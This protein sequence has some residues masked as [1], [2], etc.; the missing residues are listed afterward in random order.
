[1]FDW[2]PRILPY[3]GPTWAFCD[4]HGELADTETDWETKLWI[5]GW[6]KWAVI[7][8]QIDPPRRVDP[9]DFCN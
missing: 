4:R 5:V 6:W 8:I 1:M 7:L 2:W 3:L 9:E